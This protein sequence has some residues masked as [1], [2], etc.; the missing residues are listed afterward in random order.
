M[1]ADSRGAGT[2]L[3]CALKGTCAIN[4]N[5]SKIMRNGVV[6]ILRIAVSCIFI[7]VSLSKVFSSAFRRLFWQRAG[8][9]VNLARAYSSTWREQ[10][11]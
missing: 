7:P 8:E 9:I 5:A 2:G 10:L 3:D 4:A 6:W 1:D 11:A